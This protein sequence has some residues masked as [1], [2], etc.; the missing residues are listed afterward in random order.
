M[1]ASLVPLEA[2]APLAL[3]FT[4]ITIEPLDVDAVDV[5]FVALEE[6]P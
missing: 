4:L 1:L 2:A 3:V 6:L 5:R